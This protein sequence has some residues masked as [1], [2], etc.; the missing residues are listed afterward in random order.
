MTHCLL[1]CFVDL[2]EMS[3]NECS[4]GFDNVGR[5]EI[6][7]DHRPYME[8]ITLKFG[9]AFFQWSKAVVQFSDV[10]HK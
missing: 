2:M 9:N 5:P 1:Y 4:A 3:R 6:V 8:E 7:A 10:S